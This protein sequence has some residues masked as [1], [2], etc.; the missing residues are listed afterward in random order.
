M[1]FAGPEA[2]LWAVLCVQT[3]R[4]YVDLCSGRR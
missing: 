3:P 2:L 4:R 1:Q